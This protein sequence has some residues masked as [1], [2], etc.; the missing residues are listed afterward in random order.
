VNYFLRRD[1]ITVALLEDGFLK[2]AS[3][4]LQLFDPRRNFQLQGFT[5]RG[6]I[7]TLHDASAT[8]VSISG[9]LQAAED[10]AV[11]SFCNASRKPRFETPLHGRRCVR[12]T[13]PANSGNEAMLYS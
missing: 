3:E 4:T 7:T 11:L 9:I 5:G 10:F 13:I 8:G 6:A 2:M 1:I 12:S